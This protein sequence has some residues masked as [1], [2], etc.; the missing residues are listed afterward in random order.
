[1]VTIIIPFYNE[2][3]RFYRFEQ[4]IIHYLRDNK[5]INE[6][7]LVNDGS[8][9][10]SLELLN[11]FQEKVSTFMT[12]KIIN[13]KENKGKGHAIKMGIQLATQKWILCIDADMSYHPT[14]LDTWINNK[15]IDLQT[16]K[17]I[18]LGSRV[19]GENYYQTKLFFHRKILGKLYSHL[20]KLFLN[21]GINDTQCGFKLYEN[22]IAKKIFEIVGEDRFAFDVEVLYIVK[23]KKIK[24]NTLP[25]KCMDT[26]DTKVNLIYDGINMFGALFRIRKRHRNLRRHKQY[27]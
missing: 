26:K 7:I 14:Q 8:T 21:I 11:S 25:V 3:D 20:S 13:I 2:E 1:M 9:D 4:T 17:G 19:L 24:V 27:I 10:K 12:S 23:H 18:Y 22:L 5:F 6:L 15:W 16:S